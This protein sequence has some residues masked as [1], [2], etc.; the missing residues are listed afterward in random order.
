[1]FIS[2]LE[3]SLRPKLKFKFCIACVAAPFEQVID[4]FDQRIVVE[5]L[6]SAGVIEAIRISR[7][8]YP[9]RIEIDEFGNRYGIFF[10]RP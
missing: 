2:M 10:H 3:Y 9:S 4:L 8:G 5:Q 1:M 6:R 7:S